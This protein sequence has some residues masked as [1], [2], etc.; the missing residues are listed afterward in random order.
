MGIIAISLIILVISF[1]F[2]LRSMK[3]TRFGEE[4]EKL[5]QRKKIKGSIVFFE[6]KVEHYHHQSSKSSS[7][8]S[9][10]SSEK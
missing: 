2:A 8:S 1:L 5:F 9:S 6:D 3:D 7:P 4:L 10:S